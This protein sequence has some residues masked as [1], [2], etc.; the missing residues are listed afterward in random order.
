VTTQGEL[1]EKLWGGRY[2]NKYE[3]LRM[4]ISRLRQKIEKDP[5][6]PGCILTRP[7]IDYMP[8]TPA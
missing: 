4:H 3:A 1:L 7:G 6:K 2:H 5:H 8:A